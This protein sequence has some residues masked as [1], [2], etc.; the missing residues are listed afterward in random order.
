MK[1]KLKIDFSKLNDAQMTQV[2]EIFHDQH[3]DKLNDITLKPHTF[4]LS[5]KYELDRDY[6][7]DNDK[8]LL[9]FGK[10]ARSEINVPLVRL[11]KEFKGTVKKP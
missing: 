3:P 5:V 1:K 10:S 6:E 2:I 9:R 7:G 4:E 8:E 11:L